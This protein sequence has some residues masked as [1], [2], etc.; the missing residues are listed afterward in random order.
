MTIVIAT[1]MFCLLPLGTTLAQDQTAA[2]LDELLRQVEQGRADD[3]REFKAREDRFKAARSE[4]RSMLQSAVRERT[5]EENRS[6]RLE[7]TFGEN[8]IRTAE[9]SGAL[10]RRLG[11]LKELFG[12]LQQVSGE[13]MALLDNSLTSIQYPDRGEFLG[14]LATKMGTS[15]ELASIEEIERL[16]FEMQREMTEQGKVVR[17]TTTVLNT[18]GEAEER[19]VVRAGVFNVVSDGNYL[20]YSPETGNVTELARQPQQARFT[21]SAEDLSDAQGGQVVFGLDPTSGQILKLLLRS[22]TFTDR[23]KMG[24]IV[25]YIIMALGIVALLIALERLL[26]LTLTANKVNRQIKS[27]DLSDDNPLGRVLLASQKYREADLE[28]LE[29]KLGEAILKETPALT[30]ALMFLKIIAV[31]APLLGLLGT[32]TGMIKTFQIITLFGTGDPTLMAGGISQALVT[33]VQGL[34]VAIPTVLLHTLVTGRSRKI[35][36]VLQEQ[37]AGIVAERSEAQHA[38]SA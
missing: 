29:L 28:T 11:S 36:H 26:V 5:G 32:V 4:Q 16:W 31:V 7:S 34:S 22:P 3:Q 38:Q 30:R 14:G 21:N 10:D 23:V 2:S 37:S 12:I 24:G 17:F 8:E 15:S 6:A 19:E 18:N 35:T 1:A 25:G 33:T 9:L 13:T 20:Q 27:G